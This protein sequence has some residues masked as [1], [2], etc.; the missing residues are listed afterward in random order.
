MQPGKSDYEHYWDPLR[1]LLMLLGIPY[2]ASL[3]YS[4]ALPWDIKDFETS[5]VLTAFGAA[6]V[7]FRMP[8]FF[9]V[10]GYF[11][12]MVIGRKGR[13]PWLRQRFL[14][15]GLPFIVAL[16]LLG[17]LQLFVLQL[18][19]IAKGDITADQLMQ[20]L[21]GLLVP[22]EQWI[23]HLW[24][25]PALLAYSVVLAS[26]LF[27]TGYPPLSYAKN[28]FDRMR[29]RYPTAFFAVLC[30]FP[31]LWELMIYG[32]GL[33]AG[34]TGNGLFILYERASDPYARYVPF[35]L[36]G[37]L[38]HRDRVLFHRF[39]QTGILTGVIAFGAI[40]VAVTLRLQN[41]FSNSA[42]QVLV[43]AIAAVA[44]S[45]LLID[46]ACRFFDRPSRFAGRMTDA[47]FTIY[48]LHHPLIYAFGTLFILISLPP[49]LEFAIIVAATTG[50]AYMLH[51]AIR[52]SP[53][54]LFLFNGI[55][56]PRPVANI[57]TQ[58]PASQTLR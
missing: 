20:N 11:S 58:A 54:A 33:F 36:I 25:L 30:T 24:F 6:L 4:Y 8:A 1:A 12:T 5:P 52:R 41:P 19:G 10:A 45:R 15:L 31:V 29:D 42:L 37:A 48:L 13:M 40:A 27:L 53:L 32:S 9:L 2:H 39:R 57:G 21:P 51:Q 14:R 17:P 44:A 50:T 7:T 49:I 18:A 34:K 56:K 47:S 16:L 23:M 35:F 26:L 3:L 46:L 38:L 28:R 55:R 43:S 22:S